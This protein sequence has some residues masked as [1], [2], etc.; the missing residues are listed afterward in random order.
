MLL[1]Q[2]SHLLPHCD[3][4]AYCFKI[5]LQKSICKCG[6]F[7]TNSSA[8]AAESVPVDLFDHFGGG[9]QPSLTPLSLLRVMVPGA[10]IVHSSCFKLRGT[11]TFSTFLSA[12]EN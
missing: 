9:P 12:R 5:S 7:L 6:H 4:D 10:L 3:H 11:F 1:T 2:P 8:D